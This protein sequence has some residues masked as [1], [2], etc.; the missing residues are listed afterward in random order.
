MPSEVAGEGPRAHRHSGEKEKAFFS[1][2]RAFFLCLPGFF[3][4]SSSW[5]SCYTRGEGERRRPLLPLCFPHSFLFFLAL[6]LLLVFSLLPV[7]CSQ[8]SSLSERYGQMHFQPIFWLSSS[9]QNPPHPT[10]LCSSEEQ[11]QQKQAKAVIPIKWKFILAH[12]QH[13]RWATNST[14]HMIIMHQLSMQHSA[15][16][17]ILAWRLHRLTVP[18]L[19]PVFLCFSAWRTDSQHTHRAAEYC[20][21]AINHNRDPFWLQCTDEPPPAAKQGTTMSCTVVQTPTGKKK[22]VR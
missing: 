20:E 18:L 12:R 3:S 11:V 9:Q 19:S 21:G 6:L 13:G 15:L 4:C 8:I 14:R 5:L 2:L 17:A 22:V 10:W 7:L 16:G 1:S